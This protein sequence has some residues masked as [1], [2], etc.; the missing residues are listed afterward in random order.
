[1][2]K[3]VLICAAGMSTSLLVE[4]MKVAAEKQGYEAD[5]AAYAVAEANE[6][7]KHADIVLLGPQIRFQLA[8]IK[9]MASCP[10]EAIDMTAYGMI[11]GE[12]IINHVR[13]VLN[14]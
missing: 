8:K 9:E 11:D 4:K 2:R 5:I 3:I 13:K 14:D 12:S 10:V 7:T 1:M 6:V